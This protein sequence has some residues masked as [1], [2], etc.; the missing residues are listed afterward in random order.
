MTSHL[1]PI[2]RA[3]TPSHTLSLSIVSWPRAGVRCSLCVWCCLLPAP[4]RRASACKHCVYACFSP[5]SVCAGLAMLASPLRLALA[6]LLAL[7]LQPTYAQH[8]CTDLHADPGLPSGV[9]PIYLKPNNDLLFV[10]CDMETLGGGWTRVFYHN[11]TASKQLFAFGQSDANIDDPES[12]MYSI[13]SKLPSFRETNGPY[14][15]LMSWP[16]SNFTQLQHWRQFDIAAVNATP[17]NFVP[18]SVPYTSRG[19]FGFQRSEAWQAILDGSSQSWAYAIAQN[20]TFGGQ[21]HGP[22]ASV[23]TTALYVRTVTCDGSCLTCSGPSS[24]DCIT[25][26]SGFIITAEG[27]CI[28]EQSTLFFK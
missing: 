3:A 2:K 18:L 1:Q 19:F 4:A 20:G 26:P 23:S 11:F 16:G 14:E 7:A 9:Y 25:C 28:V 5:A 22:G 21:L 24:S 17:A 8:S 15:F 6:A 13:I 12:S 10:H 27:Q